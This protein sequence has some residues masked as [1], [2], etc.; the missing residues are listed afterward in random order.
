MRPGKADLVEPHAEAR[1][2]VQ[3]EFKQIECLT[4]IGVGLADGG[5]AD[6]RRAGI[7]NDAVDGIGAREGGDGLHLRSVQAL[8]LRERRVG[9]ADVQSVRRHLEIGRDDEV[10]RRRQLHRCG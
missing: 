5:K 8:L 3:I 6:P 7:D 4:Q 10:S 9:D 2:I 1:E